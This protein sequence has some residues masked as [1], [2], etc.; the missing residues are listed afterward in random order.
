MT[1]LASPR[2]VKSLGESEKNA[3]WRYINYQGFEFRYRWNPA[4]HWEASTNWGEEVL[5]KGLADFDAIGDS[6]PY[7][8]DEYLTEI[9]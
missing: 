2:K 7:I 4:G 1:Q 9:L 6:G 3:T 8:G 5:G